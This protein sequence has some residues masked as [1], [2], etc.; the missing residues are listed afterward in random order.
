MAEHLIEGSPAR[1]RVEAAMQRAS[2]WDSALKYFA[3]RGFAIPAEVLKR[4][5][6][7]GYYPPMKFRWR[8]LTP[9]ATTRNPT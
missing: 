4:D 7:V 6:T 2:L 9:T 1:A 3:S 5:V 8:L